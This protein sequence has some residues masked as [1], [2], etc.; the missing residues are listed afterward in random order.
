V[1]IYSQRTKS[2]IPNPLNRVGLDSYDK[3]KLK[4]DPDGSVYIYFGDSAASGYG[5]NWLPSAREDFFVIFR[6]YG[7]TDRSTTRRGACPISS[8]SKSECDTGRVGHTIRRTDA[9]RSIGREWREEPFSP[10]PIDRRRPAM[11]NR[12]AIRAF[13]LAAAASALPLSIGTA[14]AQGTPPKPRQA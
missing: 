5:K 13:L 7:L 1:I 11:T 3:A 8:A 10:R 14:L 2:F 12:C 4:A 9:M 6:F